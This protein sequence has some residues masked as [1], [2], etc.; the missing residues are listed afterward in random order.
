[1]KQHGKRRRSRMPSSTIGYFCVAERFGKTSDVQR[2]A[3]L[4]HQNGI[5]VVVDSVYGPTG[6]DF[7]YTQRYAALQND[8]INP[9]NGGSGAFGTLNDFTISD[10]LIRPGTST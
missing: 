4:C 10:S 6:G 7:A 1:M 2:F 5:A 8:L 3:D 9:F